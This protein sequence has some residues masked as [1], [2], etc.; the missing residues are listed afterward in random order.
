LELLNGKVLCLVKIPPTVEVACGVR[1]DGAVLMLGSGVIA[2]SSKPDLCD[3]AP[4][5]DWL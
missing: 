3:A 5:R 2:T 4:T 1:E